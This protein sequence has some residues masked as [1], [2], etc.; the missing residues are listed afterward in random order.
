[1]VTLRHEVLADT[2]SKLRTLADA[3]R[4]SR[5]W[6][7]ELNLRRDRVRASKHTPRGPRQLLVRRQGLPEIVESGVVIL[8]AAAAEV[9]AQSS[10]IAGGARPEICG[11]PTA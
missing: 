2:T 10:P 6:Q 4:G 8:A 7:V 1:M 9:V 5:V 11:V 3:E